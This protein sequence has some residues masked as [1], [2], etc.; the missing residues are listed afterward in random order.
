MS[1]YHFFWINKPVT[2]LYPI[3][4]IY[5]SWSEK[6]ALLGHRS[7]RCK[8]A[9]PI[10][11]IWLIKSLIFSQFVQI[12]KHINIVRVSNYWDMVT[13][14]FRYLCNSILNTHTL[15][16]SMIYSFLSVISLWKCLFSRQWEKLLVVLVPKI[17]LMF[18]QLD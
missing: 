9:K 17:V 3:D 14:R 16:N 5:P 11:S 12:L 1:S 10:P 15:L 4:I 13:S 6:P 2:L 18:P 7:K 8:S